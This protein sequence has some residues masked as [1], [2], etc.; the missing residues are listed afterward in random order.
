MGNFDYDR[1]EEKRK[2]AKNKVGK[3]QFGVDGE[4]T[5]V[6]EVWVLTGVRGVCGHIWVTI[7]L[8]NKMCKNIN[9]LESGVWE[10]KSYY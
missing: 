3:I 7:L 8:L 6:C 4:T 10:E 9:E 1:K 5:E 2:V